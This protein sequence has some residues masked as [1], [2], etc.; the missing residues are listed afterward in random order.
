MKQVLAMVMISVFI[1]ACGGKTTAVKT[2]GGPLVKENVADDRPVAWYRACC[3]LMG[4]P[5][6]AEKEC[7]VNI[8]DVKDAN[9]ASCLKGFM[10]MES[11]RAAEASKCVM[12][13]ADEEAAFWCLES[14]QDE[15]LE[16]PQP[17]KGNP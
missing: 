14:G 1:G 8:A 12:A 7:A 17:A 6:P 13:A 11:E 9:M 4:K 15:L 2:E 5:A 3:K 10:A 16:K